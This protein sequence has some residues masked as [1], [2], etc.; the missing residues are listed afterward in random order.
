MSVRLNRKEFLCGMS[1]AA[2]TA[3]YGKSPSEGVPAV[4]LGVMSDVHIFRKDDWAMKRFDLALSWCRSCD[5]DGVLIAGDLTEE[6]YEEQLAMFA[7]RYFKAFPGDRGRDG[8]HVE[9]LFVT[10][11]HDIGEFWLARLKNKDEATV[12]ACRARSL[13][14][15]KDRIWRSCLNEPWEPIFKRT[16]KGLTFVGAHWGC[17]SEKALKEFFGKNPVDPSRPFVYAQHS[18]P[19]GTVYSPGWSDYDNGS[20]TKVLSSMPNALAFSGHSHLAVRDARAIWQGGFTSVATGA[21][22]Q[23]FVRGGSENSSFGCGHKGVAHMGM[24]KGTDGST[25]LLADFYDDRIVIRRQNVFY[26]ERIADD[27]VIPL[28]GTG[29]TWGFA[30]RSEKASAP[31]FPEGARA[32]A[33]RRDGKNRAGKDERQ[34]VVSFP[35]AL[36]PV[37]DALV[38]KYRLRVLL[39]GKRLLE[40]TVYAQKYFLCERRVRASVK[41]EWCAFAEDEVPVG[42]V[43][44]VAPMNEWGKAGR[45]IA[46]PPL[47]G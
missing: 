46:S 14:H 17:W 6:G 22:T 27:W 16:V 19:R 45:E 35:R 9:R 41:E 7:E 47:R 32:T 44:C 43:V 18:H 10:G 37:G 24:F 28:P 40:R 8:R 12:A 11:N 30:A 25:V 34:V 33:E 31:E 29:D 15:N 39:D 23:M 3:L 36:S 1:A 13:V 38:E 20:S 2:W 26:G 5:V 21:V 42:S 4:R